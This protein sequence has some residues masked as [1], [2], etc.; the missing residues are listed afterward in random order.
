MAVTS[1]GAVSLIAIATEFGDTAPYGIKEFY[2]GGGKVPDASSN[3]SIPTSG[4]IGMRNFYG[5][6]NRIPVTI[7]IA[8]NT[9]NYTLGTAQIPGYIAGATDVTLVI[10]NGVYVYSTNTANAGLT[11]AALAAGD[12]VT[13]TN[14]GYILGM[15]GKGGGATNNAGTNGQAGGPALTVNR[16]VSIT[17]NSYI[18]GGG[19]G[20]GGQQVYFSGSPDDAYVEYGGGGGAGGGRGGNEWDPNLGGTGGNPGSAGG[21][22]SFIDQGSSP[23]NYIWYGGGGGGRILPGVGGA[24]GTQT[25]TYGKGGG[26]GGGAAALSTSSASGGSANTAG[27]SATTFLASGGGG[28]GWGASGGTAGRTTDWSGPLNTATGG[29]GGKAVNLN[30]YTVTWLATGTRYGAIS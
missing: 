19:G 26:A 13:V 17:N 4:A 7:T 2:R 11:I 6:Q 1:T 30:G 15:G 5:A 25:S 8:A 14:N 18:A 21:N 12:T 16:N 27:G 29:A 10:N 28:G 23:T 9:T 24:V 22:G 20:G 3:N